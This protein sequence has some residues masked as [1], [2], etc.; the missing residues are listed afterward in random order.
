LPR[1]YDEVDLSPGL[2]YVFLHRVLFSDG[3]VIEIPFGSVIATSMPLHEP[4][5]RESVG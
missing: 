1:L 3:S 2:P 5:V 4:V